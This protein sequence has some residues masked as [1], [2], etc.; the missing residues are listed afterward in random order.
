MCNWETAELGEITQKRLP[1]DV[2][3]IGIRKAVSIHRLS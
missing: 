1:I 3:G 2:S